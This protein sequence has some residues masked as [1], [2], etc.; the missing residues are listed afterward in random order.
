MSNKLF[1]ISALTILTFTSCKNKFES[2]ASGMFEA[3]EIIVSAQQNGQLLSFNVKEGDSLTKNVIIGHIDVTGDK[4]KAQ[5]VEASINALNEKT[6][7]PQEQVAFYKKQI[8]V[9]QSQLSQMM[10][11]KTRIENLLKAD[12]ATKKQ[13]DDINASVDQLQKQINVTQQQIQ[14]SLSNINTQNRSILSEKNPLEKSVAQ[15]EY[16]ISKG[17]IVCPITG[18]VLTKYAYEGEMT[19]TGKALF[20]IAN[21]DTMTL[22]AYISGDQLGQIKNGQ[23]VKV[24]IDNGKNDYKEY[25]G[26][27][28]WIAS[29]AEFT[30][31]TIQTKD[32]RANL[33]YAIKV[34]VKNDGYLKIGMYG[35]VRL[36]VGLGN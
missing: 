12:A 8:E 21:L 35:E 31:K 30:P 33:V 1:L 23:V 22:R 28:S 18:T 14:L 20:K 7:N 26:T 17:E 2:D 3:E 9:Q 25:S 10:R 32:E 5:Q 34:R 13:L 29:K 16:L 4:L 11:E 19:S 15:I 36:G 27:I 24:L 6:N